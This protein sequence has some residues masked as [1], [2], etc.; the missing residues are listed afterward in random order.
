MLR[1][2]AYVGL[3]S[4]LCVREGAISGPVF[5][6]L[7]PA[8]WLRYL[9]CVFSLQRACDLHLLLPHLVPQPPSTRSTRPGLKREYHLCTQCCL[10]SSRCRILRNRRGQDA[11]NLVSLCTI[12][13]FST[14]RVRLS[15]HR[16]RTQ[17]SQPMQFIDSSPRVGLTL[18]NLIGAERRSIQ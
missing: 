1:C 12:L 6:M 15:V 14:V 2:Y 16:W 10:H 4:E 11:A 17:P 9:L 18:T 5:R 3:S 7:L 8:L 13:T